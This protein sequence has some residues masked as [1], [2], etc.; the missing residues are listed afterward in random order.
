MNLFT[1]LILILFVGWA[2]TFLMPLQALDLIDT[3]KTRWRAFLEYRY[4]TRE[5][6]EVAQEFKHKTLEKGAT[7]EQIQKIL[8]ENKQWIIKQRGKEVVDELFRE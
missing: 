4:G 8:E 1:L 6:K 3:L 5:F 2:Y 7:Y